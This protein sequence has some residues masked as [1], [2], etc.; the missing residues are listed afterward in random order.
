LERCGRNDK[1]SGGRSFYREV[2]SLGLRWRFL[3]LRELARLLC[4]LKLSLGLPQ[5][6][7][8]GIYQLKF[9]FRLGCEA[10]LLFQRRKNP[11]SRR[12]IAF[13][14]LIWGKATFSTG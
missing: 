8:L 6:I 2:C 5:N 14:L 7:N 10:A 13:C 9:N 1:H 12:N 4:G 11:G 3:G